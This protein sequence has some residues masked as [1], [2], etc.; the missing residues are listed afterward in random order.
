MKSISLEI[1]IEKHTYLPSTVTYHKVL[2]HGLTGCCCL[3]TKSCLTFSD[4][5]DGS[6]PC[7]SLSPGA[8]SSSRPLSWW[9]Y[10]TISS[11]ATLFS[12]VEVFHVNRVNRGV[13]FDQLNHIALPNSDTGDNFVL[14]GGFSL[15]FLLHT[16]ACNFI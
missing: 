12:L 13:D 15:N 4:P 14:E 9:C 11:S 8:C 3:V 7:S 5:L 6:T 16:L 1:K 2:L 10:P